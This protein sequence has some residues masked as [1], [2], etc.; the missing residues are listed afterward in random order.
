MTNRAE[1]FDGQS[2]S[3][4]SGF[5][6]R[7]LRVGDD[8]DAIEL[9]VRMKRA[10]VRPHVG[11]LPQ[12]V[13]AIRA[14]ESLRYSALVSIMP[15]HVTAMLVA[16]MTFRTGMAIGPSLLV[17]VDEM[18]LPQRPPHVRIWK[19]KVRNWLVDERESTRDVLLVHSSSPSRTRRSPGHFS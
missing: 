10:Y 16:A 9:A 3:V 7:E 17:V 18:M 19:K 2:A 5:L 1:W 6:P 15:H 13:L 8:V 11:A 12:M 14:H 4:I